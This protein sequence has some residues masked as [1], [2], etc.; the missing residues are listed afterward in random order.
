MEFWLLVIGGVTIVG[1]IGFAV[2]SSRG[3]KRRRRDLERNTTITTS[4]IYGDL[5]A[6]DNHQSNK[7]DKQGRGGRRKEPILA[8]D[9]KHRAS[10]QVNPD[11]AES[12]QDSE[13]ETAESSESRQGTL[14]EEGAQ[15]NADAG[16]AESND[17]PLKPLRDEPAGA[18]E[19][20]TEHQVLVVYVM[21]RSQGE[22][23]CSG[24]SRV[25]TRAGCMLDERGVFQMRDDDQ[26]EVFGIVNAFEPAT[27]ELER[28]DI[29]TT[30]GLVFFMEVRGRL[31]RQRF[32]TMLG[33]ARKL[34]LELDGEL[35]DDKREPLS[36]V[37]EHSYKAD[38]VD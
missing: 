4:D 18:V 12:E 6:G 16:A 35:L 26:K 11:Q 7:D 14:I 5:G 28:M 25:L 24:I 23:R 37:R 34:A 31:D 27:F 36:S 33:L 22:F 32:D 9:P 19:I 20:Q 30:R 38:L 1:V 21:A 15:A 29:D 3:S 17:L 10:A 13:T 8:G 2:A